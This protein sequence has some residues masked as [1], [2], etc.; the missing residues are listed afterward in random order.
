MVDANVI[1]QGA[2][3]YRNNGSP[4]NRHHQQAGTFPRQWPEALN[5]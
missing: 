5:P 1:G 2:F 3:R 4:N